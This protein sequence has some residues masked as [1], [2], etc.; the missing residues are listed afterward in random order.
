MIEEGTWL[1]RRTLLKALGFGGLLAGLPQV[2]EEDARKRG[3]A[4]DSYPSSPRWV[5]KW[6]PAGGASLYPA[7]RNPL[8]RGGRALTPEDAAAKTNNFYEFLPGKAGPVYKHVKKFEARPWS[9]EIAGL[10]AE[11]RTVD[12]DELARIAP[13][14]ERIYRFRCVEA[15]SMVV[16]WTG[17]PMAAFVAWCRPKPEAKFLR[18]TSFLKPDQARG[19]KKA[20]WY[21]WPYYE[22]LRLDEA[23]HPLAMIATGIFGHGLPA[24]HGAPIRVV[25]PWKYGYKSPKSFVR[26]EFTAQEPATF[27]NDEQPDE[28]SFLSNVDPSVPHPRWSQA[29]ERDLATGDRFPTAPFNGYDEVAALYPD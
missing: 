23:R 15:W 12:V 4:V 18:F 25:V 5:P 13:L 10:V 1:E 24:Q 29:H 22:G 17:I 11:P 26:V 6:E 19:Q 27:W 9:V 20:D 21:P 2:G 7:A 8:F 14:E 28:Y 3:F 16:P